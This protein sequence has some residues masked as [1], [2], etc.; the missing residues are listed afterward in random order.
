M[1]INREN[2]IILLIILLF[3]T[4]FLFTEAVFFHKEKNVEIK[5]NPIIA[6]NE[7]KNFDEKKQHYSSDVREIQKPIIPEVQDPEEQYQKIEKEMK[8]EKLD[9]KNVSLKDI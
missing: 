1:N 3:R 5:S 8:E 6:I 2:Y 7:N 9:S 4:T